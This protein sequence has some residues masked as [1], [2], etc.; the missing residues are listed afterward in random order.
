MDFGA[1]NSGLQGE[2]AGNGRRASGVENR[3]CLGGKFLRI[4]GERVRLPQSFW[5]LP[6]LPR[7]LE[8]TQKFPVTFQ[9]LLSRSSPKPGNPSTI[10]SSLSGPL[11]LKVWKSLPRPLAPGALREFGMERVWKCLDQFYSELLKKSQGD[12]FETFYQNIETFSVFFRGPPTIY[13]H[14]KGLPIQKRYLRGVVY[15]LSEPKKRA[16]YTPP[17]GLHW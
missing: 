9:E 5:K 12:I 8:R 16:K 14:H 15:E 7:F 6:R 4:A 3:E 10:R 11:A 2:H 13:Y 17:T 1:E